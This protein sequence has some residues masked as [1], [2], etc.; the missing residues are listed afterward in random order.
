MPWRSFI[1]LPSFEA[2]GQPCQGT[3]GF[4]SICTFPHR[5]KEC[6][7]TFSLISKSNCPQFLPSLVCLCFSIM[8]QILAIARKISETNT[9]LISFLSSLF[10]SCGSAKLYF[11]DHFYFF[12]SNTSQGSLLPIKSFPKCGTLFV[13]ISVVFP[14]EA[15]TPAKQNE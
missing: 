1:P 2:N 6:N 14:H 4:D 3:K 5:L 11:S 8:F 15:E 13:F 12:P 9:T 10:F 7:F